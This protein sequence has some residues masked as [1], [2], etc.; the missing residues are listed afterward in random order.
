MNEISPL[1][2]ATLLVEQVNDA[3]NRTRTELGF[4][5]DHRLAE[6]FGLSPK[7]VSFWRVGRWTKADRA[8]IHILTQK[9]HAPTVHYL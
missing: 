5:S 3:L 1:P 7:T 4:T 8:L 2:D 9:V 6:Y